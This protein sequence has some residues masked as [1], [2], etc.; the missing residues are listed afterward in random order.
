MFASEIDP[1]VKTWL[2]I[3]P[4]VPRLMPRESGSRPESQVTKV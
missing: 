4:W 1:Q 2:L 3:I